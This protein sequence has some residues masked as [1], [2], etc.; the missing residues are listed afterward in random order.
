MF[1]GQYERVTGLLAFE[2]PA[3]LPTSW[4][5]NDFPRGL[6]RPARVGCRYISSN[7]TVHHSIA[8]SRTKSKTS[9]GLSF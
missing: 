9:S 5:V 3:V 8:I 7:S 2:P 1:R 6:A 4:V